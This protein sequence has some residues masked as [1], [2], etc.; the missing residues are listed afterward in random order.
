MV[1]ALWGKE[2]LFRYKVFVQKA[3]SLVSLVG[4]VFSIVVVV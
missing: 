2:G 4:G 3:L 1:F